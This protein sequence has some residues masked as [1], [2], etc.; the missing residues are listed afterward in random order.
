M[1]WGALPRQ[2]FYLGFPRFA[3]TA[4]TENGAE[5]GWLS[6]EAKNAVFREGGSVKMAGFHFLY[7]T[8]S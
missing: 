4:S 6:S 7:R 3:G 5:R 1:Q 8:T 2:S